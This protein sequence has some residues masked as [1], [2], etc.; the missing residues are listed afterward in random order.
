MRSIGPRIVSSGAAVEC[1]ATSR[2]PFNFA[3]APL[4]SVS[5]ILNRFLT[6]RPS[7]EA[8]A[9][10][11]FIGAIFYG[12]V[13]LGIT[14]PVAILLLPLILIL[15]MP[16]LTRT[17]WSV[18]VGFVLL[19]CTAVPVLIQM[20][21]GYGPRGKSDLVI[22][23]P[24]VYAGLTMLTLAGWRVADAHIH[25]SL[26]AGGVL[27]TVLLAVTLLFT[28][29]SFYFVPGQNPYR[30]SQKEE[31]LQVLLGEESGGADKAEAEAMAATIA[32]LPPK[33][34][35]ALMKLIHDVLADHVVTPAEEEALVQFAISAGIKPV[36]EPIGGRS[37]RWRAKRTRGPSI[38]VSPEMQAFYTLKNRARTP[39]GMSNYLA[40]MFVFLFNVMLYQRSRWAILFVV[41]VLA[42]MSRTGMG[43]LL[44]SFA[45]SIAHRAGRLRQLV[46]VGAIGTF[47]CV[48]LAALMWEQIRGLPGAESLASRAW[49]PGHGW[50]ADRRAP[51]RRHAPVRNG[52]TF[53]VSN[54]L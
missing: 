35:E 27:C 15:R 45:L 24:F 47:V 12:D 41:L 39:L 43:F 1:V 10:A 7:R 6:D 17:R 3:R 18:P 38:P 2:A 9:V 33:T 30:V 8:L 19:S 53:R 5:A 50:R 46:I 20:L 23:L 49:Y 44:I 25:R 32:A 26:L 48:L 40:V 42:T 37:P 28:G 13:F 36:P 14:V 4:W 22:Y 21:G 16:T 34:R 29:A 52:A 31:E 11:L 54:Y 51:D